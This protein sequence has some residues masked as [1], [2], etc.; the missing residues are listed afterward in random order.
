MKM[1]DHLP[2]F[3]LVGAGPGDPELISIKGVKA[4]QTADAILYDALIHKDLL[5]FA[6]EDIP[7]ICVGK[8]AG[9][10]AFPQTEIN[11]LIV[12]YAFRYGHVIR[13]KGGDP[14]IFG[15][16]AE[17]IDYTNKFGISSE[18]IPG[19]S[20]ATGIPGLLKIP[21]TRR[22]INQS[23]WV[24]TGTTKTGDLSSDIPMAAQ[25]K[26]TVIILMGV[27]KLRGIVSIYK[28]FGREETPIALIQDGSLPTQKVAFGRI[29]NILVE[30]MAKKIKTPAIIVIGEVLKTV[31]SLSVFNDHEIL[32]E[33]ET[34]NANEY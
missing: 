20:S 2:R 17:E 34:I 16:G 10:T 31:E 22:H 15:R 9:M 6:R 19:I 5:D 25:S 7:K 33:K 12:D 24:I 26:A 3:T 32:F 27:N 14:M 8:R 13:L 29:D 11:Q 23:F 18:V 21:V 30:V 28:S 1:S 4:I